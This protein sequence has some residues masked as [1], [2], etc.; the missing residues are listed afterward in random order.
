MENK[1]Y[2]CLYFNEIRKGHKKTTIICNIEGKL[3]EGLSFYNNELKNYSC[4]NFNLL[5][6]YKNIRER[7]E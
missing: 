5:E 1:C 3:Q 4:K 6:F 2:H 7:E